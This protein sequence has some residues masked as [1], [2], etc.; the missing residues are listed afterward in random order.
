MAGARKKSKRWRRGR[1]E[2]VLRHFP[3]GEIG[4]SP[5]IGSVQRAIA[6][7]AFLDGRA[8]RRRR[9]FGLV[10]LAGLL[11]HTGRVRKCVHVQR[12][13]SRA[14]TLAAHNISV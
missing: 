9:I 4:D 1:S 11:R 13:A 7:H 6:L 14:R 8:G 2:A 12:I 3:V 10:V 5:A